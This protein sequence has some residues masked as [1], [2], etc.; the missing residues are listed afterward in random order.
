MLVWALVQLVLLIATAELAAMA[1]LDAWFSG[2][3]ARLQALLD[4]CL[5]VG[6]AAL[7]AWR[8]VVVPLARQ[9]GAQ[10]SALADELTARRFAGQLA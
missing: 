9:L 6:L 4:V 5:L 8:L 2:L 3:P 10:H 1:M 7:P